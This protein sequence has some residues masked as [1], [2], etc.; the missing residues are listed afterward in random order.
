VHSRDVDSPGANMRLE[1]AW[2]SRGAGRW[3]DT[4]ARTPRSHHIKKTRNRKL[5]LTHSDSESLVVEL[6]LAD[7]NDMHEE[8]YL[9]ISMIFTGR[10]IYHSPPML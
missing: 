2:S 10:V 5:T 1:M 3:G 7:G 6:D 9:N 4:S 8:L